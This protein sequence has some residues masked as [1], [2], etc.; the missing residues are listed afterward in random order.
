[1]EYL[2]SLRNAS[3]YGSKMGCDKSLMLK[4]RRTKVPLRATGSPKILV[5][6]SGGIFSKASLVGAKMV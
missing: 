5:S 6:V 2:V 4:K 3:H 1:M